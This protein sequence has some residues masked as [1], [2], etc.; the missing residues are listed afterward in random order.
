MSS[1]LRKR[2]KGHDE[3]ITKQRNKNTATAVY[4]NEKSLEIDIVVLSD[5]ILDVD[6]AVEYIRISFTNLL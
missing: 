1:I 6:K 3:L 4:N 5:E 2:K